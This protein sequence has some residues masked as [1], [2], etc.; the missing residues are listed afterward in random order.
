M[1]ILKPSVIYTI[2]IYS[3]VEGM[4]GLPSFQNI[5]K[6]MLLK[7]LVNDTYTVVFNQY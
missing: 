3:D 4:K 6:F 1:F 7:N 2:T 5:V